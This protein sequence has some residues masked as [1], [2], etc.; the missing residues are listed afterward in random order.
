M[1]YTWISSGKRLQKT[2]ESITMFNGKI[3][4]FYNFYGHFQ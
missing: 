2:M 1:D 4:Y 3:H